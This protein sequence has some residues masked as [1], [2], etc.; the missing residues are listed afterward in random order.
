MA[1]GSLRTFASIALAVGVLYGGHEVLSA[2]IRPPK[3][4]YQVTT[5]ANGLTLVTEGEG[6]MVDVRSRIQA[7]GFTV[8]SAGNPSTTGSARITAT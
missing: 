1:R 6:Q 5:L 3:L 7:Y 4:E 2:A 8:S